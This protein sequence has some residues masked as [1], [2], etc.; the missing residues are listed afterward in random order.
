[1]SQP[2][3]VTQPTVTQPQPNVDLSFFDGLLTQMKTIV[4]E[5]DL[6]KIMNGFTEGDNYKINRDVYLRT[7]LNNKTQQL[8]NLPEE[9]GRAEKNYYEYNA[10]NGGGELKYKNFL[11]DRYATTGK[12]FRKN[13]IEKQQEFATNLSRALKQYQGQLVF[14]KQS[15]NLLTTRKNEEKELIK[16]INK[17]ES[18]L[19]TSERKVV[20]EN[21][22]SESLFLYRRVMLFIYY[23]AIISYIIF[24]NFIPDELYKKYTVWFI[25]FIATIM[26]LILNLIIKW[27][28][29]M[30]DALSYWFADL[31]TKDVYADL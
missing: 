14:F 19:Q 7:E 3:T 31:P 24:G 22:N 6:Q 2:P 18:I 15:E 26:P 1:M 25:I 9:I 12:E 16:K 4:N 27:L 17:F 11:I 5:N 20:Y 13:S 10:G 23:S 8:E 29:V 21:K 30:H 28:F